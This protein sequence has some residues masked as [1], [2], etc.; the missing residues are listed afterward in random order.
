VPGNRHRNIGLPYMNPLSTAGQH[1]VQVIVDQ[2]QAAGSGTLHRPG[3]HIP[4][5]IP[6]GHQL[7]VDERSH[8]TDT[9]PEEAEL[10]SQGSI[11]EAE[12]GHTLQHPQPLR[13][14]VQVCV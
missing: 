2:K 6:G 7:R 5:R 11:V 10:L 1:Q 9:V 14:P 4:T 3:P 8:P 12:T 13:R